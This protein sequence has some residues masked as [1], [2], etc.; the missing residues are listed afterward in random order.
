[1]PPV[2]LSQRAKA[3]APGKLLRIAFI[4]LQS[5]WPAS[6]GL[7]IVTGKLSNFVPSAFNCACQFTSQIRGPRTSSCQ[8]DERAELCGRLCLGGAG[9]M[10]GHGGGSRECTA[11]LRWLVLCHLKS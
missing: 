9:G 5:I 1:M 4:K 11:G 8:R 6:Y 3:S 7:S 2:A 10:E